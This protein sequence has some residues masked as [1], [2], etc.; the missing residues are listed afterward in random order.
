MN[1]HPKTPKRTQPQREADQRFIARLSLRGY[2]LAEI[3]EALEKERPYSLSV[4]MICQNLRKIR[5]R[6]LKSA[7]N[8]VATLKIRELKAL[9]HQERE[10]WIEWER[11]KLPSEQ[12][13]RKELAAKKGKKKPTEEEVATTTAA[14]CGDPAYMRLILEIR[15]RRAKMLGLDVAEKTEISGPDGGPIPIEKHFDDEHLTN[16]ATSFFAEGFR[17]SETEG[18]RGDGSPQEPAA[19]RTDL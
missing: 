3:K 12:K 18:I 17:S 19:I 5:D 7:E 13:R 10:L 8:D 6:W 16:W 14:Q 9:D 1:P 11:S 4:S 2:E 15:Q